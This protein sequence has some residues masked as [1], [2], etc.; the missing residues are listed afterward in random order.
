M[1]VKLSLS[2]VFICM[3][4]AAHAAKKG[5]EVPWSQEPTS[6]IGI[7]L[8]E[9]LTYQLKQCP[10]DYSVPDEICYQRPFQSYYPL[11]AVPALGLHGYTAGVMTYESQIRE[12]TLDTKVDDYEAVKSMFIQKYG[13]PTLQKTEAVKTKVGATFQNEK[14]YWDGRKV[15]IILKKYSD[16]IEKSSVSVINKAVATKAVEAQRSKLTENASQL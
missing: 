7:N 3:A 12:I 10:A 8:E 14:L 6:F 15:S 5:A 11:F 9:K 1:K 2:L 16:T 13:K 4:A